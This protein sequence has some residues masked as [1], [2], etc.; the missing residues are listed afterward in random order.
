MLPYSTLRIHG[1]VT[2]RSEPSTRRTKFIRSRRFQR[3][4]V[5]YFIFY[6]TLGS[7]GSYAAQKQPR[8]AW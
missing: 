2:E 5:F 4:E 6:T 1:M 8:G 3:R 7:V